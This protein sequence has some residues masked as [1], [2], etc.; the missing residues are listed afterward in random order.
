MTLPA[1]SSNCH[2][3]MATGYENN[4]GSDWTRQRNL[5]DVTDCDMSTELGTT[6]SK[7]TAA[8]APALQRLSF[9]RHASVLGSSLGPAPSIEKVVRPVNQN[10]GNG[11]VFGTMAHNNSS[12]MDASSYDQSAIDVQ[13]VLDGLT[14]KPMGLTDFKRFLNLIRQGAYQEHCNSWIS[15][16]PMLVDF[17]LDFK[18]YA[19]GFSRL[20][21][22]DQS[23]CPHPFEIICHLNLQTPDD[24]LDSSELDLS[25]QTQNG[26]FSQ[27]ENAACD[28]S[29]R[30]P[31]DFGYDAPTP[32]M[33]LTNPNPPASRKVNWAPSVRSNNHQHD[34]DLDGTGSTLSATVHEGSILRTARYNSKAPS[35][36]SSNF[37]MH[38]LKGVEPDHQ[39]MRTAFNTLMMKYLGNSTSLEQR[40]GLLSSCDDINF[41]SIQRTNL[42]AKYT[43]HPAVLSGI[44][45]EILVGLNQHVLPAFVD[46]SI[47]SQRTQ[48]NARSQTLWGSFLVLMAFI[49]NLLMMIV[50]SPLIIPLKMKDPI[51]RLYRLLLFP[52]IWMGIALILKEL[53]KTYC[54]LCWH[55]KFRSPETGLRSDHGEARMYL[56]AQDNK[57]SNSSKKP[58]SEPIHVPA[59]RHEA[60]RVLHQITTCMI[61]SLVLAVIV[62]IAFVFLPLLP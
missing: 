49:F 16:A 23:Q 53:M 41:E 59:G 44:V 51:P 60:S 14:S 11:I 62:Q 8:P 10:T 48:T 50:P 19:D 46:Y 38:K 37:L 1:L 17:L 33:E 31:G 39:P 36:L 35:Q 3:I 6:L 5:D 20:S 27:L 12:Q 21:L 57:Y 4:Y 15:S 34:P 54:L 56:D 40:D 58:Q 25:N 2:Q 22:R 7:S 45:A 24:S 13:A 9:A 55:N 28:L 52:L 42:E 61:T 32:A 29:H 43:N 30:M 47:T 26:G 18:R